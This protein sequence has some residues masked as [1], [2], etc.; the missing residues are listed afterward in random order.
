MEFRIKLRWLILISTII[1]CLFAILIELGNDE[2]YYYTYAL[3]P[4]CNHFDHPPLTGQLI[5]FFTLNLHWINTFSMRLGPIVLAAF[6]T[7]LIAVILRQI[8]NERAAFIAAIIYTASI[9]TSVISGIFILPD[10]LAN[11][12]WLGGLYFMLCSIK[13]SRNSNQNWQLL[14]IGLCIGIAGMSKIH[15]IVLWPGFLAYCL[16]L[17]PQLLKKGSL[18]IS[19]L[20]TLILLSPIWIWNQEYDFITWKFHSQR[21]SLF[22]AGLQPHFFLQAFLGQIFYNNPLLVF[23]YVSIGIYLFKSGRV[24]FNNYKREFCLLLFCGLP[25]IL[26]AT[27]LSLFKQVLPHWSGSGFFSFMLISAIAIDQVLTQATVPKIRKLFNSVL[28]FTFF[29]MILAV[30]VIWFYPGNFFAIDHERELGK[31]DVTLDMIGWREFGEEFANLRE[32]DIQQE[33][34]ANNS[35]ILVHKWFPAGHIL[36]YVARPLNIPIIGLGRITDLHKFAWLNHMQAEIKVDENAYFIAPSNSYVDPKSIYQD[37]FK[38]IKL[39]KTLEQ[40][41]SGKIIR[42]W[43]IYH[44]LKATHPIGRKAIKDYTE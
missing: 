8:L 2:V 40:K 1:R 30:L 22:H 12:F 24:I 20:I 11:T 3:Q 39:V 14:A 21:V 37:D 18:Y 13:E 25:I 15:A 41:R 28:N 43:Y 17:Q 36:F 32:Q 33:I 31:A 34:M 44:L 10:V 35:A 23:L 26:I 19:I 16:F 6:N 7:W 5:R 9:Y 38:E 29:I 4:D 42:K 27:F